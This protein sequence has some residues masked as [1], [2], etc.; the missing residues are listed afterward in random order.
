MPNLGTPESM[1][2]QASI[3][4][5]VSGEMRP[6]FSAKVNLL[7]K[8]SS[9]SLKGSLELQNGRSL[10]TVKHPTTYPFGYW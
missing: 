5:E 2:V 10:L 7:I 8:S 4:F 1:Q 3:L 9:L 6:C